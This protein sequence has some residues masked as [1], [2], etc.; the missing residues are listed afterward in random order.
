ML[1]FSSVQKV[2]TP[3]T[4]S[5]NGGLYTGEPFKGPWGNVPVI[6]DTVAMTTYTL[7]SGNP[8]KEALTQFGNIHRPGNS[9]L[10]LPQTSLDRLSGKHTVLCTSS[11]SSTDTVQKCKS[12]DAWT[13]QY[14]TY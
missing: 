5:L 14:Q 2:E 11:D 6:P 9:A 3:L 12:F 13:P 4:P 7:R 8:P 1:S 10:N